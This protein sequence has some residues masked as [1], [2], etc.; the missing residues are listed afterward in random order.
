M[1]EAAAAVANGV[2]VLLLPIIMPMLGHQNSYSTTVHPPGW[3]PW[4]AALGAFITAARLMFPLAVLA[5]WRTWV[6]A[7]RRRRGTRSWQ[8]VAEAGACGFLIALVVLAR[9][10]LANP[11]AAM[12][13]VLVYGGAALV[14]GLAVGLILHLSAVVVLRLTE[15]SAA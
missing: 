7:A 12:I 10:I 13:Y 1:P 11:L 5:A 2:I 3:S 8:G 9:G 14:V 15:P 6:H 4:L